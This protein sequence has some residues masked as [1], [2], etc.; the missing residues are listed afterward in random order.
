MNLDFNS[1]LMLGLAGAVT[2]LL[3]GKTFRRILLLPFEW[4]SKKTTTKVDDTLVHEARR[5]LGVETPTISHEPE[6][7]K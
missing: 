2:A 7:K 6:E 3:T 5:D 1:I 4:I